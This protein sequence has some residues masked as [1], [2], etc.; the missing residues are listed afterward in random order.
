M[1]HFHNIGRANITLLGV[2]PL[3]VTSPS[4]LTSGLTGHDP[5]DSDDVTMYRVPHA[6]PLTSLEADDVDSEV[7]SDRLKPVT[8][9]VPEGEVIASQ[10]QE[11]DGFSFLDYAI[12]QLAAIYNNNRNKSS[13]F[14]K[15][16]RRSEHPNKVCINIFLGSGTAI[17]VIAT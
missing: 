12:F 2:T 17:S 7:D 4:T 13:K 16:H 8:Y 10:H 15:R 3:R 9:S 11:L 5:A 14:E 1:M 6:D